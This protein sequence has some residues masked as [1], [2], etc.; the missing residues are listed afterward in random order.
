MDELAKLCREKIAEHFPEAKFVEALDDPFIRT[1][2]VVERVIVRHGPRRSEA[3]AAREFISELKG[4]R[5]WDT[6]RGP[7]FYWAGDPQGKSFWY[8]ELFQPIEE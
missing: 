7:F 3:S 6:V 8:C 1:H 4:E 2:R 5:P